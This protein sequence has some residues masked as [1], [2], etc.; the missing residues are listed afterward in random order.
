MHT[1]E[2]TFI[3]IIDFNLQI[4]FDTRK[5]LEICSSIALQWHDKAA[6]ATL[7]NP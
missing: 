5:R 6:M 1:F 3:F 7:V 4:N 2:H